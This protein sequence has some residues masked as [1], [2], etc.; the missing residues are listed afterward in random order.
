M[1][2][3]NKFTARTT[4]QALFAKEIHIIQRKRP[5]PPPPSHRSFSSAASVTYNPRNGKLS[6]YH[7]PAQPEREKKSKTDPMP[8]REEKHEKSTIFKA[9]NAD[10]TASYVHPLVRQFP[11]ILRNNVETSVELPRNIHDI[12]DFRTE[13]CYGRRFLRFCGGLNWSTCRN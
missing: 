10:L 13:R 8:T 3:R 9:S 6:Q 4:P 12:F 7:K 2:Q 5:L 1:K 11:E